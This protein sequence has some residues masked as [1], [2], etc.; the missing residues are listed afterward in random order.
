[1]ND[2]R[3]GT[4]TGTNSS[5]VLVQLDG[6]DTARSKRYKRLSSYSATVGDRVLLAAI[7]G[8]YVVI[9]KVV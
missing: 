7:S 4:V 2:L 9:G 8:S 6:E 1:M 5:G 3:L